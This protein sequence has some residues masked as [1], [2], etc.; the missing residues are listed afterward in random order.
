VAA[1][2]SGGRIPPFWYS[3]RS[4]DLNTYELVGKPH[5]DIRGDDIVVGRRL[6]GDR[7]DVHFVFKCRAYEVDKQPERLRVLM[8]GANGEMLGFVSCII[9]ASWAQRLAVVMEL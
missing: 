2:G 6:E 3:G 5:P 1:A 8:A 9:T 4:T 7:G